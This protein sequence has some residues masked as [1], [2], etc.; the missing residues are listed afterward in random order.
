VRKHDLGAYEAFL[1]CDIESVGLIDYLYAR[2]DCHR[3]TR[4]VAFVRAIAY[5]RDPADPFASSMGAFMLGANRSG[6]PMQ[7]LLQ[8]ATR[9]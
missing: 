6:A 3:V 1:L 5:D 9:S 8:E 2:S 4:N 7:D